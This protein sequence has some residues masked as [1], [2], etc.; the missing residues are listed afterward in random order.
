MPSKPSSSTAP[1]AGDLIHVPSDEIH[2]FRNASPTNTR[3][4]VTA[5]VGLGAFFEEAGIPI[6]TGTSPATGPP[7]PADIDRALKIARKHGHRFR[8]EARVVDDWTT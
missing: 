2:G 7:P 6:S 3:T 1:A 8:S 4:F 5:T